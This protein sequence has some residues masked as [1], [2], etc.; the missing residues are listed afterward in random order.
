MTDYVPSPLDALVEYI[1]STHS[2]IGVEILGD[3]VDDTVLPREAS[4]LLRICKRHLP[5]VPTRSPEEIATITRAQF[6]RGVDPVT[7]DKLA[8]YRYAAYEE[9]RTL[10]DGIARME[11]FISE[12]SKLLEVKELNNSQRFHVDNIID[13]MEDMVESKKKGAVSSAGMAVVVCDVMRALDDILEDVPV[14]ETLLRTVDCYARVYSVR[15]C[16]LCWYD[17]ARI[18]SYVLRRNRKGIVGVK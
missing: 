7:R 4:R 1:C 13:D 11:E 14:A 5:G 9:Y 8:V 18:W 15:T 6:L 10:L 17:R 2:D 3:I 16:R 12:S